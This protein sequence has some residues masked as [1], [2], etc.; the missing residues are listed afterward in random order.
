MTRIVATVIV[1]AL[2]CASANELAQRERE[3][4][5]HANEIWN[6]SIGVVDRGVDFW[7]KKDGPAP[8]TPDELVRAVEFLETLTKIRGANIGRFGVIP[9]ESLERLSKEWKDW[10]RTYGAKLRYDAS[11]KRVIVV[12]K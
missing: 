3:S 11:A 8:Y 7:K 10:H 9:D 12:E 2:G 5:S 6:Q 1:L 4:L